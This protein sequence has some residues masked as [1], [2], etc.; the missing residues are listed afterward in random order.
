MPVSSQTSW[1][2]LTNQTSDSAAR[3][4]A[5]A[6]FVYGVIAAAGPQVGSS[7]RAN[8]S[9]F[10]TDGFLSSRRLTVEA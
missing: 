2:R 3:G 9:A 10:A 8:G 7:H 1:S 4:A 6:A 5:G